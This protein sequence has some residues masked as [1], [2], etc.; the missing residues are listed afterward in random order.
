MDL[1]TSTNPET[2]AVE[3]EATEVETPEE[4]PLD[5]EADAPEGDEAPED[6]EELDIDGNPLRVP[7]SL[8]EK[9]KARMMMQADY[10]QKTQTLAEQRREYE[11]QRQAFAAEEMTRQELFREEA[12]LHGIRERLSAF[13]NVNWQ[14]IAQQNPQ[15]AVAMQAEYTQLRDFEAK[16]SG[17]V[18]GRKSE[19]AAAR[20]QETAIA[21]E[22]AREALSTPD[23]RLAWD[24]RFDAERSKA[25][26]DFGLSAGFTNEELSN[27]SHPQMIKILHMAYQYHKYLEGQRKA[28]QRPAAEPAAKVTAAK[29]S[30]HPRNPEDLTY[31]QYAAARRAGRLK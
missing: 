8:A 6:E 31:V 7:K 5:A 26:T 3:V 18:E 27:T 2:E 19:L 21:L 1:A 28:P 30:G 14:Q 20:E 23:P 4:Q 12:Q 9:L 17:H 16:L 10:T 11:A 22:K 24:G 29:S 25:L 15:Q 13:Q